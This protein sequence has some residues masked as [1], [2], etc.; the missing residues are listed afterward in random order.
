MPNDHIS[1]L[2]RLAAMHQAGALSDEEF[3][4]EKARVLSGE[5]GSERAARLRKLALIGGGLAVLAAGGGWLLRQQVGD[6]VDQT[7]PAA[8]EAAS[9]AAS[10]AA[11]ATTAPSPSADPHEGAIVVG[12]RQGECS[13]EKVLTIRDV[14]TFSN[15]TLKLEEAW[16]GTSTHLDGSNPSTW[17]PSIP[18]TW[19]KKVVQTYVFCSTSAPGL[20]F[21]DR[22]DGGSNKWIGHLLDPFDTY[23]YNEGSART[24]LRICHQLDLYQNDL[25]KQL[26]R[27]GYAPGTRN[28]QVDLESPMQLANPP[29]ASS[30]AADGEGSNQ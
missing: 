8:S 19:E 11:V 28:V 7:K 30:D 12:C 18:I 10:D 14:R 20:A 16:A 29:A 9:D 26:K 1:A 21:R 17:S 15:G 3:E 4:A 5:A 27:L 25:E 6:V 24:Y 23:G 2:E 13:W 22:W